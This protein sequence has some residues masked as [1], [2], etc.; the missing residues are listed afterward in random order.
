MHRSFALV[1]IVSTFLLASCGGGSDDGDDSA[2]RPSA[3][4]SPTAV[5]TE[6]KTTTKPVV[7]HEAELKKAVTEYTH[8]FLTGD[9]ATAY[10]LLS[11]TCRAAMPLSEFAAITE[12]AR[13]TYG[14]VKIDALKVSVDGRKARA[15]YTFPVPA[16]N[17]S[18]EPWVVED[19]SWKNDDC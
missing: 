1:V 2:D 13:D 19:G 3:S 9:G 12:Q 10:G 4:P 16:I 11:A 6:E 17:Q 7:D 8:A 14:D 5:P 15:T 18:E